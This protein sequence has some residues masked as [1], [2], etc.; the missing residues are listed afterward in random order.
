MIAFGGMCTDGDWELEP[1]RC[2]P[3]RKDAAGMFQRQGDQ[4][5]V[6]PYKPKDAFQQ[7]KEFDLSKNVTENKD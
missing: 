3:V 7:G 2:V 4:V 6:L 1:G 5:S